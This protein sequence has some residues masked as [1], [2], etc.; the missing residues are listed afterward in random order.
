VGR[1][2]AVLT[3]L[4][5]AAGD[6]SARTSTRPAEN[7]DGVT[8]WSKV[9][10]NRAALDHGLIYLLLVFVIIDTI[11]DAGMVLASAGIYGGPG[12]KLTVPALFSDPQRRSSSRRWATPAR[13]A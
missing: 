10:E 6:Q 1:L 11:K 7:R 3:H 2:V 8:W 12:G 4:A 13:W 9:H 5:Q